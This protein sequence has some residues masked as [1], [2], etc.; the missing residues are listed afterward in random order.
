LPSLRKAAI[1]LRG[2]GLGVTTMLLDTANV[3][4]LISVATFVQ[5][6]SSCTKARP[7]LLTTRPTATGLPRPVFLAVLIKLAAVLVGRVS[8]SSA[9]DCT[10]HFIL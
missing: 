2:Q 8:S 9:E 1:S 3:G 10:D 6:T 4:V 5:D 7:L